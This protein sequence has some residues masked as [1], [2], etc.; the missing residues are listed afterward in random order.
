MM[1]ISGMTAGA[2]QPLTAAEKVLGAP[3]VQSPEE[4]PQGR[5]LAPVMDEYI[6]EEKQEPSG[7]C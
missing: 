5:P 1:S 7:R 3:K 4:N 2:A 6:P